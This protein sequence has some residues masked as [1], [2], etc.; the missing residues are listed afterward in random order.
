MRPPSGLSFPRRAFL[1][2]RS[3]GGLRGGRRR[4]ASARSALELLAFRL[5]QIVQA[6]VGQLRPGCEPDVAGLLHVLDDA[7]QRER[8][9]RPS[10]DVGMAR[11]RNVFRTLGRRLAIELV[12]I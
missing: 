12:E 8:A 10:D 4:E 6:P 5:E 2:C 9:A 7:A 11:E 3:A 1:F